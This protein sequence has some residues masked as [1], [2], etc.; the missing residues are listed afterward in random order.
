MLLLLTN[1][2]AALYASLI[3]QVFHH[4]RLIFPDF[5]NSLGHV[6][7]TICSVGPRLTNCSA[8]PKLYR[9]EAKQ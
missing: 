7:S 5:Y 1:L 6:E 3:H 2:P 4:V 8:L 9:E